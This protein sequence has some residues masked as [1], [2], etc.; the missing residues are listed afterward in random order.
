MVLAMSK[1]NKSGA[2]TRSPREYLQSMLGRDDLHSIGQLGLWS[3]FPNEETVRRFAA[4]SKAERRAFFAH[5]ASGMDDDSSPDPDKRNKKAAPPRPS[6]DDD[7]RLFDLPTD[8][9]T[10]QIHSCY[11]ELA[12]SFHPDRSDGDTETMQEINEAYQ[13]LLRRGP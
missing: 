9:S 10:T 1:H 3:A 2:K 4:L 5:Y 11:R 7:Y 8:A 12:L 6:L 13:R